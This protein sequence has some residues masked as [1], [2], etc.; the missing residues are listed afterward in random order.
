MAQQNFQARYLGKFEGRYTNRN[1]G[2]DVIIVEHDPELKLL[3]IQKKFF[4]E[5][6]Y[7]I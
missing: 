7:R 1:E 4:R 2:N 6:S 5:W 3:I